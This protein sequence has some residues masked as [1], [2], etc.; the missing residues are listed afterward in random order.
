MLQPG[1]HPRPRIQRDVVQKWV[2]LLLW[3]RRAGTGARRREGLCAT[4]SGRGD[5]AKY[6]RRAWCGAGG[7]A[8][9]RGSAGGARR[10]RWRPRVDDAEGADERTRNDDGQG[11]RASPS[12]RYSSPTVRWAIAS[13]PRAEL[14]PLLEGKRVE[15]VAIDEVG[16]ESIEAGSSTTPATP[17]RFREDSATSAAGDG[18]DRTRPSP[19][20]RRARPRRGRG[21]HAQP[22]L[23]LA[24]ALRVLEHVRRFSCD[25]LNPIVACLLNPAVIQS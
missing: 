14:R 3:R 22:R 21:C 9:V 12:A 15:P 25:D 10:T 18:A 23:E 24:S 16:A 7:G 17:Q 1:L 5:R 6:P 19:A 11:P 8:A 20:R 13:E 4:R 2:V